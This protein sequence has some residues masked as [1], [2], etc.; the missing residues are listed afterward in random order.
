MGMSTGIQAFIPDTDVDYQKHKKILL[1]CMEA[2]VSLPKET[3]I[4]FGED[5]PTNY[6]L[7]QKLSVKLK[8]GVHYKDWSN[9]T[10]EG[11]E[12]DLLELPKGVTKLRFSNSW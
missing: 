2:D 7:E 12:V 4:Y 10:S 5:Y 6:L 3:A 1:A 8:Q 9:E 11:F